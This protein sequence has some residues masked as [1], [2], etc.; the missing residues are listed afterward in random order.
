MKSQ[1]RY[2]QLARLHMQC[3]DQGFLGTLGE[4]FLA[5]MYE[6]IDSSDQGTLL[7]EEEGGQLQGF[8]T[9]GTGMGS[10]YR[11]MLRR[12]VRL[13]LALAPALL[14]A[15]K[16]WRILEIVRYSRGH[17]LPEGLP[18]AELLTIVVSPQWRGR[19]V[20]ERL[21]GRLAKAFR[22]RGID[23]FRIAVGEDLGPAHRFYR[24]MGAEVVG[25]MEVHGGARSLLYVHEI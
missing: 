24:R 13:G 25:S 6:A 22:A 14:S 8:V 18:D 10:F 5:L 21:Y 9:G 16:V 20:A 2:R 15:S 1:E 11:R 23:R 17:A 4:G 7:V 3:L 12:P 19:G